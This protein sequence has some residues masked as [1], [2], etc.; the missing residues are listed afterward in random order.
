[1]TEA[2]TPDSAIE[3]E[4]RRLGRLRLL[5]VLDTEPEPLFDGLVHLAASI[6]DMPISLVSLVDDKRQWFKANLG[7][8]DTGETARDIAFCAHAIEGEDVM[9]VSDATQD[10]RFAA[11]PLVLG[12]PKIRFYA[13]APITMP[14]GERIGTLCVIDRRPRELTPEQR[15]SLRELA[16]V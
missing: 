6:C 5:A 10:A 2:S 14:G 4:R 16:V 8:E 15:R 7:L 1:M 13:G 3:Q 9:Q 11:N 12:D